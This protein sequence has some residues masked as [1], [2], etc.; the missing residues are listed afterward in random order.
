VKFRQLVRTVDTSNYYEKMVAPRILKAQYN[1][2][3]FHLWKSLHK[4]RDNE[5]LNMLYS[6]H[7]KFLK[8]RK[9][10][11][12]YQLQKLF[13]RNNKWI[14]NKVNK[15]L[16]VFE[17]I[18]NDGFKGS[19]MILETS[20]VKNEYNSGFEIFEGHHRVACVLILNIKEIQCQI[21]RRQK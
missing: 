10:K 1:P 2:E 11:S 16:G 18:K 3:R 9:D 21:I 7:Y 8:N 15:F 19:I 4:G 13:G 12:Y 20:I 6:P 5:V 17:S 14:K